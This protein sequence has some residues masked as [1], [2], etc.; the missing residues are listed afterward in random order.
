MDSG[1]GSPSR[2]HEIHAFMS[3]RERPRK[4]IDL[5]DSVPSDRNRRRG[6]DQAATALIE[7]LKVDLDAPYEST[8]EAEK[9]VADPPTGSA[10]P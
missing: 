2:Q 4:P 1:G 3:N 9:P 8:P 7:S 5:P 10:Q 6:D